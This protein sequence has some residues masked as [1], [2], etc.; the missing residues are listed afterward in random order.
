MATITRQPLYANMCSFVAGANRA[1]RPSS[2]VCL[3]SCTY[4]LLYFSLEHSYI[5]TV[6]SEF[7]SEEF[8]LNGEEVGGVGDEGASEEGESEEGELEEGDQWEARVGVG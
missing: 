7:V 2:I 3:S 1:T 8:I 4:S 6:G 5:F